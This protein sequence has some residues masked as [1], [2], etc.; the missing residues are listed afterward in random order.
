MAISESCPGWTLHSPTG[1]AS[2]YFLALTGALI[3]IVCYYRSKHC[4]KSILGFLLSERTSG[5][6]P[7]IFFVSS[8]KKGFYKIPFPWLMPGGLNTV[9]EGV[10]KYNGTP[11][12]S[13]VLD[14]CGEA[15]WFVCVPPRQKATKFVND[16][17][18]EGAVA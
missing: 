5:V 9:R 15:A 10:P 11:S 7:V 2:L 12:L 17:A 3:V 18:L 1:I 16:R 4:L 6:S 8:T 14:T 13:P